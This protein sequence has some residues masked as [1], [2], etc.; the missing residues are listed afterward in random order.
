MSRQQ[1]A[2]KHCCLTNSLRLYQLCKDSNSFACEFDYSGERI[3]SMKNFPSLI[4][5]MGKCERSKVKQH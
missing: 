3:P 5:E 1:L 4:T 2:I